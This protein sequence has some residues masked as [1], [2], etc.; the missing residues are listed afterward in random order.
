M[1]ELLE[2]WMREHGHDPASW[3]MAAWVSALALLIAALLLVGFGAGVAVLTALWDRRLS[4]RWGRREDRDAEL[5]LSALV[6]AELI[7]SGADPVL[8]RLSAGLVLVGF[9][10]TFA[11]LP[12]G[13]GLS[14]TRMNVGVLYLLAV[15]ALVA[16]G[17]ALGGAASPGEESER[18]LRAAATLVSSEL[19]A[20]IALLVPVI[21]TGSLQL[22]EI[23][24]A[25]GGAPWDWFAFQTPMGAA[26]FALVAV[27]FVARVHWDRE[28]PPHPFFALADAGR[29]WLMA[30][31]VTTLF[32]GGW[33]IPGI[34]NVELAGWEQQGTVP[35]WL[36]AAS[37]AVFALKTMAVVSGVLLLRPVWARLSFEALVP[38]TW[39]RWVPTAMALVLL[40]A[41]A[42]LASFRMFGDLAKLQARPGTTR[43]ILH[44]LVLVSALAVGLV[45]LLRARRQMAQR[46]ARA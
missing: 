5:E 4:R 44:V 45:L 32:L 31:L 23:V 19:P 37:A 40:Q 7:P 28:H 35:S 38:R 29:L 39:R 14:V 42:E 24:R 3:P 10:L 22:E 11:V 12:L 34:R 43:G 20:A 16:V 33:L 6:H 17:V 30:A 1:K 9:S 8:F 26:A 27:P 13:Y 36:W 18:A 2:R 41:A 46:G 21:S 15:S 25:Q